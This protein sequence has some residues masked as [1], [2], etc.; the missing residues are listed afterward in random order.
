MD[1]SGYIA[2]NWHTHLGHSSPAV[3][4]QQSMSKTKQ[5]VVSEEV[6]KLLAKQEVK[7]EPNQL[8]SELFLVPKKDGSP[9][10]GQFEATEPL[11][12]KAE[13]QDGRC[14][15]HQRSSSACH[16]HTQPASCGSGASRGGQ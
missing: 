4:V 11:R 10:S 1:G 3:D 2:W 13:V 12:Q 5:S 6:G 15:G 16:C 9:P 7:E 8:L 14:Q